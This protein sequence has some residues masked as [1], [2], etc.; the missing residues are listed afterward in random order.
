[1]SGV[2]TQIISV[3]L[4]VYFSL[5]VSLISSSI[6]TWLVEG[7][8]SLLVSLLDSL[9]LSLSFYLSILYLSINN[10]LTI[11][12]EKSVFELKVIYNVDNSRGKA[13]MDI[14]KF[15]REHCNGVNNNIRLSLYRCVWGSVC[16]RASTWSSPPPSAPIRRESS[17]SGTQGGGC[18]A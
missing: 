1:M 8:L 15:M 6:N 12:T 4:S 10:I 3:C 11:V 18:M 17:F 5:S 9:D 13:T 7:K 16:H 14:L 2:P